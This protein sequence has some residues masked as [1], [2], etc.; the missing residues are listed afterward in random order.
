MFQCSTH[1]TKEKLQNTINAKGALYTDAAQCC[2][3]DLPQPAVL[4]SRPAINSHGNSGIAC[5]KQVLAKYLHYKLF[6]E[7]CLT[8]VQQLLK[9]KDAVDQKPM[10]HNLSRKNLKNEVGLQL[11]PEQ[12]ILLSLLMMNKHQ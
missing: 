2:F 6:S 11:P 9:R 7:L 4:V 12:K 8:T 3:P 1:N 10:E 5:C